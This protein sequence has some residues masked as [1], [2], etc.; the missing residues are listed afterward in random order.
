MFHWEG[1][2]KSLKDYME[3]ISNIENDWDVVLEKSFLEY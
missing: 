2:R 1:K 3:R